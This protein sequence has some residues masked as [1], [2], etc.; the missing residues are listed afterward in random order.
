MSFTESVRY[1]NVCYTLLYYDRGHKTDTKLNQHIHDIN[2]CGLFL[3]CR[4]MFIDHCDGGSCG[5][6]K[7]VD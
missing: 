5:Y 4:R 1:V 7:V 2:S 3:E 6:S